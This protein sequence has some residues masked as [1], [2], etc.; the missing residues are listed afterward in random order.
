MTRS[1]FPSCP[2]A[3]AKPFRSGTVS[4]SHTRTCGMIVSQRQFATCGR[5]CFLNRNHSNSQ[6][7][8]RY[9]I[10]SSRYGKRNRENITMTAI[11]SAPRSSFG[12]RCVR[13][14]NEL[15]APE[16]TEHRNKRHIRH[17]W[18]CGKCH[19]RFATVVGHQ[20]DGRFDK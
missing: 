14:D 5:L 15:I 13:C 9:H 10:A 2:L 17:L 1:V 20:D 7:R 4:M 16:W 3:T 6:K 19:C 18:Q 8:L 11:A 12:M